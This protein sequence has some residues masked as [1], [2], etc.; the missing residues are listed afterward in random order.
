VTWKALGKVAPRA[1]RAGLAFEGL[2]LTLIESQRERASIRLAGRTV[3]QGTAREVLAAAIAA[4]RG[5]LGR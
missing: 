4:C 5:L 3:Q 1:S 2:E